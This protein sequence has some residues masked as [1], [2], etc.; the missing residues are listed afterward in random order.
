MTGDAVQTMKAGIL[1]IGDVYVVNKADLGERRRACREPE[2]FQLTARDG[3][4]SVGDRP[5]RRKVAELLTP[6]TPRSACGL[7]RPIP[8]FGAKREVARARLEILEKAQRLLSDALRMRSRFGPCLRRSLA[9]DVA[10]TRLDPTPG[11]KGSS[12]DTA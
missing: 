7:S 2:S 5:P 4:N 10:R 3:W 12:G 8:D 11:A 1:E 9:E 6:R